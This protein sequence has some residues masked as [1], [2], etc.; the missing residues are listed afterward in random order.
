MKPLLQSPSNKDRRMSRQLAQK[1]SMTNIHADLPFGTPPDG[2][3]EFSL[4]NVSM[5][6]QRPAIRRHKRP[7]HGSNTTNDTFS[8][9]SS[10]G[11][12]LSDEGTT[13][14]AH[15]EDSDD[16]K[17][18]AD[19]ENLANALARRRGVEPSHFMPQLLNLIGVNTSGK[20]CPISPGLPQGV[21]QSLRF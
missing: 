21:C 7:T 15:V 18:I 11:D 6:D 5:L 13:H 2:E 20:S 10:A 8:A 19:I 14:T 17:D 9:F 16:N 12:L 3:Q 4:A 1:K